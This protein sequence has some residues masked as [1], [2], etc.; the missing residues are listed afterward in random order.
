MRWFVSALVLAFVPAA[1]F[2]T[3]CD[4]TAADDAGVV[5]GSMD[6]GAP[7]AD[8]DAGTPDATRD[9]AP[10]DAAPGDAAPADGGADAG[11]CSGPCSAVDLTATFG[12]VTETFDRV[13]FGFTTVGGSMALYLE[14]HG[15]GSPE[16][17]TMSS[18]SP[19]RTLIMNGLPLLAEE[20]F[21]DF[22]ANLLD[23]EGTLTSAPIAPSTSASY[24]TI[25]TSLMPIDGAFV[26][27]D[28]EAAYDGGTIVGHGYATYC[29]SL[30][31]P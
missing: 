25:A 8:V 6:T 2:L 1:I 12:A 19:D 13:Q 27:F 20:P 23:F 7:D 11:P 21:T 22:T 16:C 29:E 26:A 30:S 14:A 18:P 15:G 9:A 5:D 28:L 17:P 24:V 4:D 10:A 31:D 3:G